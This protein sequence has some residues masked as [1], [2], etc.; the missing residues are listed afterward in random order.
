[1]KGVKVWSGERHMRLK[2]EQ[3]RIS[4]DSKWY[5]SSARCD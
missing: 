1:M 4:K 3:K 2:E 5:D